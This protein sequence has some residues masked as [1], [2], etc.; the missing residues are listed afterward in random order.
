MAPDLDITEDDQPDNAETEVSRR[1]KRLRIEAGFRSA[2]KFAEAVGVSPITYH[3]HEN[4][5]RGIPRA[6]AQKYAEKLNVP[7]GTL[8]YGEALQQAQ[9]SAIIGTVTAKG[10]ITM[11]GDERSVTVPPGIEMA[12]VVAIR[13]ETEELWPAYRPGDLVFYRPT[14]AGASPMD[15][16]G[17][18]CIILLAD[19][20]SLL[21]MFNFAGPRRA[22]LVAFSGPPMINVEYIA[23]YPVISILRG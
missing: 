5:R 9:L 13:V 6:Q 11:G 21:R 8:L 14:M 10:T 22:N 15:C 4:G 23:A 7:A 16:N 17:K 19:G 2:K 3:H 1:L 20:T 12:G 18:D